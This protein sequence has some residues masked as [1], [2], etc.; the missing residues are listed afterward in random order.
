MEGGRMSD[1]H[2]CGECWIEGCENAAD[3]EIL[4]ATI[5]YRSPTSARSSLVK[6]GTI[7]LCG[8]HFRQWQADGRLNLKWVA[9]E[10]ALVR[11]G[12]IRL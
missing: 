4:D 6:V 9:I 11:E 10:Q 2:I 3:N 8:G 1:C 7:D 5:S 12:A